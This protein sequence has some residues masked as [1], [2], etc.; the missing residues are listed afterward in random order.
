MLPLC[1]A[2]DKMSAG[3]SLTLQFA[4]KLH[5]VEDDQL[6]YIWN[7]EIGFTDIS[8]TKLSLGTGVL[9]R[10]DGWLSVEVSGIVLPD[11]AGV[12]FISIKVERD[13]AVDFL[14]DNVSLFMDI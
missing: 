2:L 9:A 3:A 12:E 1:P 10:E 14:I 6:T 5:K 13:P 7:M 4:L 8:S 11:L